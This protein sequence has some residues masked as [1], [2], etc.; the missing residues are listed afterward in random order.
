MF[1]AYFYMWRMN[2]STPSFLM[3]RVPVETEP[4]CVMEWSPTSRTEQDSFHGL[5]DPTVVGP[6]AAL[7]HFF[8]LLLLAAFDIRV[9]RK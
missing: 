8:S 5:C 6:I 2:L 9:G 7:L 3:D 1:H 4:G